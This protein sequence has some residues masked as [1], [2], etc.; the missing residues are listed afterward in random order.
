MKL[1]G[2]TLALMFWTIPAISGDDLR[3][4]HV[5]AETKV[6]FDQIFNLDY[7]QAADTFSRL[8]SQYPQHPAPPLYL[9]IT[10]WQ[11]E[12]FERG[13][14]DM[15]KF[16][17]P[18]YFVRKPKQ[19]MPA[20]TRQSFN[21]LVANSRT[22]AEA[23]L[24]RNPDDN[25]AEYYL[26]VGYGALAAFAI[27]I[28]HNKG[29]ALGYGKKSYQLHRQIV[30]RDAHYY[31]S[32]MPLGMYEYIVANLPWYAKFGARIAGYHGSGEKALEYLRLAAERAPLVGDEARVMLIALYVRESKYED[33]LALEEYLHNKYPRNSL[34]PR[35]RAEIL[36]KMG[37]RSRRREISQRDPGGEAAAERF[38]TK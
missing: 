21:D 7:D 3:D 11:R 9:A 35:T 13:D 30:S 38:P 5:L 17:T 27:T 31:D 32:Y 23:V 4:P 1:L 8:R 15:D 18:S 25:N 36:Q 24:A 6:G 16:L 20:E 33:A 2:I 34:L 10:L 29:Q 28:D 22:L 14:L 12:L 19:S 26:A 37:T